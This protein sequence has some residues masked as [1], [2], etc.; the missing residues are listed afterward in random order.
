M[1]TT[2]KREEYFISR[3]IQIDGKKSDLVV[4]IVFDTE[5]GTIAITPRVTTKHLSFDDV[6]RQALLQQ[7]SN[8]TAEA[9]DFSIKLLE[10]FLENNRPE[11]HGQQSLFTKVDP[12][13]TED[14]ST[15][16]VPAHDPDDEEEGERP[17]GER[18]SGK[19]KVGRTKSK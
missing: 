1:A 7:V 13:Y 15:G 11:S 3:E 17:D 18:A 8:M 19:R 9:Y 5:K 2:K 16:D 14:D 4:K 10:T 6:Q 12:D